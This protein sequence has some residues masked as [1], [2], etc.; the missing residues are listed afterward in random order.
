MHVELTKLAM[1]ITGQELLS[2]SSC[3]SNDPI[4]VQ[5]V[6]WEYSLG[7]YSRSRSMNQIKGSANGWNLCKSTL[8]IEK[9]VTKPASKSP[10]FDS[11]S[12][13]D[14]NKRL[15]VDHPYVIKGDFGCRKNKSVSFIAIVEKER[16]ILPLSSTAQR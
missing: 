10:K 16:K 9:K 11:A 8:V 14:G 15:C 13:T 7:L 5:S 12:L 3:Y 1:C 6:N 4:E 2:L